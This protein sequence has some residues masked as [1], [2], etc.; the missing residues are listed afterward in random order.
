MTLLGLSAP[1][2][3]I[4]RPGNRS[5]LP[6]LD[7]DRG[8]NFRH[9]YGH[10]WAWSAVLL[11]K[12]AK[13]FTSWSLPQRGVSLHGIF[14]RQ[15]REVLGSSAEHVNCMLVG[16]AR[17]FSKISSFLRLSPHVCLQGRIQGGD[18]GDRPL[19]K[20]TNVTFFTMILYNAGNSI[21]V[22]RPF[23]LHCFVTTVLWSILYVS[24]SSEL[25]MRLHCKILL[26]KYYW[27]RPARHTGWIRPCLF[28]ILEMN[29]A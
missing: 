16:S 15:A 6:P 18:W 29:S 4:R 14:R 8:T 2:A 12:V 20:P 5:P 1:S 3:V 27:N 24:Y 7:P 26:K 9:S 23:C 22:I 21:R 25:V 11:S 13:P 28:A 19:L 10:K 17:S